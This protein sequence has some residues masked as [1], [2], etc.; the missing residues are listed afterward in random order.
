MKKYFIFLIFILTTTYSCFGQTCLSELNNF[1][2]QE[3]IDSFPLKNPECT[4]IE[5]N[6]WINGGSTIQNLDGLNSVTKIIGDLRISGNF[7]LENLGGLENLDTI[8]GELNIERTF[9]K[10]VSGLQNLIHIGGLLRIEENF[11][12]TNLSNLENL[13]TIDGGII[14]TKNHQL[15]NLEGLNNLISV[16]NGLAITNNSSLLNLDG[17][18]NLISVSSGIFIDNN[19]ALKNIKAL[20]N[21]NEFD[22]PIFLIGNSSLESLQG[23]NNINSLNISNLI[24]QSNQ[25]LSFCSVKSICNYIEN[26]ENLM[27]IKNNELNC[28]TIDEVRSLCLSNIIDLQLDKRTILFPNPTNGDLFIRINN[29]DQVNIFNSAGK[30]INFERNGLNQIKLN[31]LPNGIYIAE[32]IINDFKF[33]QKIIK[34]DKKT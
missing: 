15:I 5:G 22:G 16:K 8:G 29:V 6:V 33:Y 23:I 10:N 3:S 4:I 30:T 26:P 14:C 31:N 32:I 1:M 19:E 7:G 12:L 27:D 34:H 28:N 21:L 17:L 24:I 20:N 25:A 18:E 11:E 2:T 13:I 9:L